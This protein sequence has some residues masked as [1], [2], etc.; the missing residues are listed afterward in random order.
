[1]NG[2]MREHGRRGLAGAVVALAL[3]ACASAWPAAATAD[4]PPP[5]FFGIAPAAP[6]RLTDEEYARMGAAEI[7]TLRVPFFWPH[8]QPPPQ[9]GEPGGDPGYKWGYTDRMVTQATINGM[10]VLPFVYGTPSWAANDP[11]VPP[12]RTSRGQRTWEALFR[13]LVN[14]YGPGGEFWTTPGLAPE[15]YDSIP[16]TDWQ[17]WNEPNSPTFMKQGGNSPRAYARTLD[18]AAKAVRETDP[19]AR[20]VL[21]GMFASPRGGELFESYLNR[22]FGIG[23]VAQD[24][25]VLGMHPYAPKIS[26]LVM[27]FNFARSVMAKHGI[28][29]PIWVTELGWPTGGTK[30]GNFRKTPSGQASILRRSFDLLLARRAEWGIQ[31]IVWYT[32]RDNRL[33]PSCDIC[34]YSGLFKRKGTP[35]PAWYSFVE[36][37]GGKS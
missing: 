33:V 2:V 27:R 22:L 1:M 36:Y 21:A 25:D 20:I 5:G 17:V 12:V 16:I 8:I 30:V 37:T 23:G 29:K 18:I 32:W 13:A 9:A 11:R 3:L 4:P 24:F 35:K 14:R 31:G 19:D 26:K 10:Q 15:G 28:D 34:S 6:E 7:G